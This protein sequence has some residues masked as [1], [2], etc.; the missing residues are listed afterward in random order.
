MRKLAIMLLCV[1]GIV[2]TTCAADKNYKFTQRQ[3]DYL[4]LAVQEA[5]AI[6]QESLVEV[7]EVIMLLESDAGEH[8]AKNG[9]RGDNGDSFH[10]NQVQVDAA[11]TVLNNF[12]ELY[13]RFNLPPKPSDA[14]LKKLLVQPRANTA[15][16]VHYAWLHQKMAMKDGLK[17]KALFN[18]VVTAHNR[19]YGGARTTPD[20]AYL[21][22]GHKLLNK[23][24][25][26]NKRMF[27][28]YTV[29]KAF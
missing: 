10:I 4:L 7:A 13:K 15:L 27:K 28:T 8:G 18:R 21:R 24:R 3:V 26:Y 17:G 23:A 14:V 5:R 20:S 1:L 9:Y 11:R 2:S 22:K 16:A 25:E 12:P 19:G 6:N 29:A